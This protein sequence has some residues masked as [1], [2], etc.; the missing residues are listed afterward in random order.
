LKLAGEHLAVAEVDAGVDRHRLGH[1]LAGAVD[2]VAVG[3]AQDSTAAH[4]LGDADARLV[5]L[6]LRVRDRE[7]HLTD[8]VPHG[9]V[10]EVVANAHRGVPLSRERRW[11]AGG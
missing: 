11:S 5:E 9:D 6:P 3:V 4:H 2:E 10:E 8:H 7:R 1:R